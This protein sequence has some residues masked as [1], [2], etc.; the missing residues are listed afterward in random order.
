MSTRGG[1]GD[2]EK[3]GRGGGG[4]LLTGTSG[5]ERATTEGE[6]SR[7]D[8]HSV[9]LGD[10]MIFHPTATFLEICLMIKDFELLETSF[11]FGAVSLGM[12]LPAGIRSPRIEFLWVPARSLGLL[13]TTAAMA[14]LDREA[15]LSHPCLLQIC[16]KE[17]QF[18]E[19]FCDSHH[20]GDVRPLLCTR[21]HRLY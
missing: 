4:E 15:E 8:A 2:G 11:L 16:L 7:K 1:R 5:R 12:Q 6:E 20:L 14:L 13:F 21:R 18:Q 3:E 19:G 10:R 9:F 17:G